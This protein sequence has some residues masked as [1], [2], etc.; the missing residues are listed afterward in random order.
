MLKTHFSGHNK[1]W[2]ALPAVVTVLILWSTFAA[3]KEFRSL[4]YLCWFILSYRH[5]F[6]AIRLCVIVQQNSY[7]QTK[8]ASKKLKA[9][10]KLNCVAVNA[11]VG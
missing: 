8:R 2:E 4:Y 6:Y 11:K 7:Q 3:T 9:M 1:I 10:K 5:L